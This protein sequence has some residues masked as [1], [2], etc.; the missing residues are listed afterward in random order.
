MFFFKLLNFLCFL[1]CL[2]YLF[3]L[4]FLQGHVSQQDSQNI[5][6]TLH[7]A[8]THSLVFRSEDLTSHGVG[9]GANSCTI[10]Y[11]PQLEGNY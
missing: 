8:C 1:I 4:A 7:Q 5:P 9:Y 3:Q 11:G 10:G 6:D 2:V